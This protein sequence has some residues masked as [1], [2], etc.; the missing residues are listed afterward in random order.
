MNSNLGVKIQYSLV[1]HLKLLSESDEKY[2]NLYASWVLDE[3]VYTNALKAVT[4]SFPHYS[5]HDSSHSLSIINKIEMLLGEER[6]KQLSPTDTF[7]ILESAFVHDLGMITDKKEQ[8][9]LWT[10]KKFKKYLDDVINNNY[11]R[12]LVIAAKYIRNI[13]SEGCKKN[14][15]WPVNVKNYV[16]ILIADYYRSN[17]HYRSADVIMNSNEIDIL[18]SRN[19]LIPERIMRLI[20]Q[21][22]IMHGVEFDEIMKNLHKEDNGIGT[23]RIH[24]RMITCFLRLGDLLDLDNGRFNNTLEKTVYMP[25][26]SNDHK[27]KHESITHFLIS[28]EKIEVSAI[29]KDDSI[30]RATRQ[31]FELLQDELKNLSSKWSDIVPS[32]LIGG[33]PSLGDIN[34]SIKDNDEVTEQLNFKFNID[35]KVA[36]EFIEGAGIYENKSDC[37]REV[38]QN[39]LDA[40]KIQIWSDIISGKYD[41]LEECSNL[42]KKLMFSSDLPELIKKMYPIN[43]NL[44]LIKEDK[45][46]ED[47]YEVEVTIEDSG[48]GISLKDLK[49]M[50]SV[51]KSWKS[52]FDKY[53]LIETMPNWM[54]PTGNFGIG[55]H[56]LFMITD[57]VNIE[58][59]AED[60]EA[61]D[62]TFIS[63]KNN[64]YISTKINRNRRRIGS[65]FKFK[66]RC[67]ELDSVRIQDYKN[68][69]NLSIGINNLHYAN[70]LDILEKEYCTK[71]R[72]K[73]LDLIFEKYINNIDWIKI[74]KSIEFGDLYESD[75]IN[76]ELNIIKKHK[77]SIKKYTIDDEVEIEITFND[78]EFLIANVRDKK[79]LEE[80][81]FSIRD[82]TKRYD[83][84]QINMF[85]IQEIDHFNYISVFYKNIF[86]F[87]RH[88]YNFFDIKL[89]IVEDEAK[90]ILSINRNNIKD[91]SFL[92]KY[93]SRINDNIT[94]KV[95]LCMREFLENFIDE[96]KVKNK[97]ILVQFWY[98][99]LY[100]NYYNNVNNSIL[101]QQSKEYKESIREIFDNLKVISA[102]R[103]DDEIISLKE[104]LSTSK[105]GICKYGYD[106]IEEFKNREIDLIFNSMNKEL[107]NI[108]GFYEFEKI[109]N[110]LYVAT[111]GEKNKYSNIDSLDYNNIKLIRGFLQNLYDK[112]K[113]RTFIEFL[114]YKKD[115]SNIK[116][117][118]LKD[119]TILSPFTS[120]LDESILSLNVDECICILEKNYKFNELLD[121]VNK[122]SLE[123]S[124]K[125]EIEH[126]KKIREGY[127][128]LIQDYQ[129]YVLDSSTIKEEAAIYSIDDL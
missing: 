57:K 11:D 47:E 124:H 81:E 105:V 51:G 104:V 37:I 99:I 45:K 13:E 108:L 115:I 21:I 2:K 20:A 98:I 64:G 53:E 24:P 72:I 32:Y 75:Y 8:E 4:N 7:L 14:E 31:W 15:A 69:R 129:K 34:L 110:F 52:D 74:N 33:P 66:F 25:K 58:T 46:C 84:D 30:Y 95:I 117:I 127:K 12:D 17:H 38:I 111:R 26:S 80:I 85:W 56:S 87:S 120:D 93:I 86:C 60:S 10:D 113:K 19:N 3:K 83:L 116:Y 18:S 118:I 114:K 9:E 50:E 5:I 54:K 28:P 112:N 102:R 6:I 29:C 16:T 101:I 76:Q 27:E 123:K 119:K 79:Y 128:E 44:K 40:T 107:L 36:F 61:Y 41:T 35:Q 62:I 97:K 48:C 70:K 68:K 67:K 71:K 103:M 63:S 23:D 42:K 109:D 39:S 90:N 1:K 89:N 121:Y 91:L 49:R 94:K 126:L 22:S 77:N 78:K 59:K 88:I 82:F 96:N 106:N 43:I 55:I 92:K 122:N 125:L 100:S 73:L 65:T